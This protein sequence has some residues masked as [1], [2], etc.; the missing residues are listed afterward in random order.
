MKSKAGRIVFGIA[1]VAV[2]VILALKAFNIE[3]DIFFDGWWSLFLIV[4][5]VIGLFTEKRKIAPL[6]LIGIGVVVL[7]SAQGV[8]TGDIIWPLILGILLIGIGLGFIFNK[9]G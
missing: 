4:P 1:I 6:V 2:G 3:V 7:L 8:I 5:G 9:R